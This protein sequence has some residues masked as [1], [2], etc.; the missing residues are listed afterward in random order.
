MPFALTSS[1]GG[2]FGSHLVV[3]GFLLN[4]AMADFARRPDEN[5]RPVANRVEPGKR[6]ATS[7]TPAIVLDQK[8]GLVAVLGSAGGARIPAYVVQG[9]AGLV[10]W[11]LPPRPRPSRPRMWWAFPTGAEVESTDLLTPLEARG[12]TVTVRPMRS[13]SAMIMVQPTLQGAA[14]KRREGA[15]AGD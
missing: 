4:A 3:R 15:V 7:M 11:A 1:L 6:P 12:Q 13:D 2:A 10:D 8:G 9:V 5:G 14:D